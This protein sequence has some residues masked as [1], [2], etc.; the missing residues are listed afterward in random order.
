MA[1]VLARRMVVGFMFGRRVEGRAFTVERE[2]ESWGE[3][4][5]LCELEFWSETRRDCGRGRSESPDLRLCGT[6]GVAFSFAGERVSPTLPCELSSHLEEVGGRSTRNKLQWSS[7]L[8]A[9]KPLDISG[10]LSL[11]VAKVV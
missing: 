3:A 4:G 2:R 8:S 9:A 10:V 6:T 1:Q 7:A 11:S 5:V